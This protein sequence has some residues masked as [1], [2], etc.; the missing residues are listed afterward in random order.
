MP[1]PRTD[2]QVAAHEGHEW[3]REE[4]HHYEPNSVPNVEAP[5]AKPAAQLYKILMVAPR[6]MMS[7]DIEEFFS[8]PMRNPRM[9]RK[10]DL[11][12]RTP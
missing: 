3:R 9:R 10:D 11:L 7:N 6:I 12:A 8:V 2:V 4:K 1:K 5:R